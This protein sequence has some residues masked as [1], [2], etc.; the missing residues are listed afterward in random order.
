MS[1]GSYGYL[2]CHVSGLETQRGDIER[3]E[4]R[5]QSSGYYEA[6]RSTREV[7]RLLDGAERI[8]ESLQDVWRAVEWKD[9]GDGGEDDVQ[10]AVSKFRPWPPPGD[11][12]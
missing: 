10:E 2:Y 7:L 9:S 4:A 12:G 1:G 5:L 6:A 3:M 8:A 11:A